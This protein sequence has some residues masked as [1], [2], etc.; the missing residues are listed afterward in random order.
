[1]GLLLAGPQG[2]EKRTSPT[3]QGTPLCLPDVVKLAWARGSCVLKRAV[4]FVRVGF[5]CFSESFSERFC[6]F[7]RRVFGSH[8]L[9]QP[10][11]LRTNSA[12]EHLP[13]LLL[14]R[15]AFQHTCSDTKAQT[16]PQAGSDLNVEDEAGRAFSSYL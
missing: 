3:G 14:L 10:H 12:G 1:M 6:I 5:C 8:G 15:R 9:T 7:I 2:Q 13:A 11:N 16:T 4:S